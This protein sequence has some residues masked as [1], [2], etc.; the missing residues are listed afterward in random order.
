M[1]LQQFFKWEMFEEPGKGW[2]QVVPSPVPLKVVQAE[3]VGRLLFQEHNVRHFV[4]IHFFKKLTCSQSMY[5]SLEGATV[6][7]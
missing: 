6:D 4:A 2:R 1:Q 3:L 7:G 5:F